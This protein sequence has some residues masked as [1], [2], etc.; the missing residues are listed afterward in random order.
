MD[1]IDPDLMKADYPY[2]PA[3]DFHGDGLGKVP[4]GPGASQRGGRRGTQLWPHTTPMQGYLVNETL[5]RLADPKGEGGGEYHGVLE[6]RF[7]D[8]P[9]E[10]QDSL[11]HFWMGVQKVMHGDWNCADGSV[12]KTRAMQRVGCVNCLQKKR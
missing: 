10:S 3:D 11:K 6:D 1:H 9:R 7:A 2:Y 12:A 5:F 8:A 4:G